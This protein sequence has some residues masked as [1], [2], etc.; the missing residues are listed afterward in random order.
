MGFHKPELE[1]EWVRH[2]GKDD[3]LGGGDACS[4]RRGESP[5]AGS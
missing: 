5:I 4:E 1:L 2:S 3:H